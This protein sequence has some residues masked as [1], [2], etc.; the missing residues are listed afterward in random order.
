MGGSLRGIGF[1]SSS[2][3]FRRVRGAN[4]PGEGIQPDG[5]GG[6]SRCGDES[7]DRVAEE[8]RSPRGGRDGYR[9]SKTPNAS[10][11]GTF[12]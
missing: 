11:Y 8:T 1:R 4:I 5:G 3:T 2:R 10:E 7:D 9:F 12:S 6:R